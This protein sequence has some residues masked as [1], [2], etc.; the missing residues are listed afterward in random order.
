MNIILIILFLVMQTTI[1]QKHKTP[2]NYRQQVS[3]AIQRFI[4]SPRP[5]SSS[6]RLLRRRRP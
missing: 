5:L 1:K 4:V 2:E 3:K 6:P